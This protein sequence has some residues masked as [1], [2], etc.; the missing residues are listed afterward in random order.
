MAITNYHN[1]N[2]LKG[3]KFIVSQFCRSEIRDASHW[4]KIKVSDGRLYSFLTALE[5]VSLLIQVLAEFSSMQ[6]KD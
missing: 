2:G 3:H 6:L 4:A 1:F 5:F